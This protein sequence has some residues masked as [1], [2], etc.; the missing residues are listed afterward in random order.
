MSTNFDMYDRRRREVRHLGQRAGG[1]QFMFRAYPDIGVMDTQTWL[2][3]LDDA[4]WI[5]DEYGRDYTVDDFLEAVEACAEGQ[6]REHYG[7]D[8]RDRHGNAFSA[9]E[10]S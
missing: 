8:W 4:E 3:Q 6:P 10:F 7:R 2:R 9:L 1:W 5:R